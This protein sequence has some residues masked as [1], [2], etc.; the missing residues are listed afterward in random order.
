MRY[1]AKKHWKLT[2]DCLVIM[3]LLKKCF[4]KLI[5]FFNP[6]LRKVFDIA[7]RERKMQQYEQNPSEF[8][9]PSLQQSCLNAELYQKFRQYQIENNLAKKIMPLKDPEKQYHVQ[10][11]T[12]R[13]E[14]SSSKPMDQISL[15]RQKTLDNFDISD[16]HLLPKFE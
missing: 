12:C 14:E 5:Q 3:G 15:K 9:N 16:K 13:T 10:Y 8:P 4:P 7:Y 11:P 2:E 1:F 6:D